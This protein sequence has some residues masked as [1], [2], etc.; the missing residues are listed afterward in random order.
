MAM[1]AQELYVRMDIVKCS[2]SSY[3]HCLVN[4]RM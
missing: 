4:Y 3:M 1:N 2:V